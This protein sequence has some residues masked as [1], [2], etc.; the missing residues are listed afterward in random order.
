MSHTIPSAS[1]LRHS[2]APN[3]GVLSALVLA[4]WLLAVV[5]L[6]ANGAFVAA[7]GK[8]PLALLIA[9]LAP[10]AAF[11][12]AFRASTGFRTFVLAADPRLLVAMQAWRF[13]GFA[14]VALQA[15][16]ILPG[17]FALP[18]GLGDMA[19][20]LTAPL[21]LAGLMQSPAFASSRTFVAWNLLGLL[22]LVVA[23]GTGAVGSFLIA[24]AGA[25]TTGAMAEL[26]LVLVPVFF[27]PLFAMMHFAALAKARLRT[28]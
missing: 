16:R 19:I 6:G 27:V 5:I 17:Y 3:A 14:F 10:I 20:G 18:A 26:P 23:L 28:A 4:A 21:M 22:D 13:A 25:I 15:H 11:L 8:P 1:A 24:D 9:F 2:P 12:I 7:Q